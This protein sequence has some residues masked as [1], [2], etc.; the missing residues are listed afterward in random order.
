M[1]PY[2]DPSELNSYNVSIFCALVVILK[3][4]SGASLAVYMLV[5]DYM[6][7]SGAWP[8]GRLVL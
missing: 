7:A 4:P 3:L 5:N 2:V 8:R 6:C 1:G